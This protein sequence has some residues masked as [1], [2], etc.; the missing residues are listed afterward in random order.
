MDKRRLT[1]LV[2]T[3][4]EAVVVDLTGKQNGRGAYVCD[5]PVCWDKLLRDRGILNQAL[6]TAVSNEHLAALATH[7]PAVAEN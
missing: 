4:D 6:K 3:T 7:K 2:R 5:Q 1:R